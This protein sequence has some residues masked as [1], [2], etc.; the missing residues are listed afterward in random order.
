MM[1]ARCI[2]AAGAGW[3]AAARKAFT[4]VNR[5]QRGVWSS[6]SHDRSE[7]AGGALGSGA[8]WRSER[9]PRRLGDRA[10]AGA[11]AASRGSRLRSGRSYWS[12]EA[13][14][15]C[16]R[17][18]SEVGW[19]SAWADPGRARFR[20]EP[21]RSASAATMTNLR[22]G[23]RRDDDRLRSAH[24]GRKGGSRGRLRRLLD[25]AVHDRRDGRGIACGA[26]VKLRASICSARV[27][28]VSCRPCA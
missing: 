20:D 17:Q 10:C 5:L 18:G 13:G 16:V 3:R 19:R 26:R 21:Q 12:A 22:P 28:G 14:S 6:E 25:E 1:C 11:S 2:P 9:A 23:G 27:S 15:Y 7:P 4:E 8:P 24:V